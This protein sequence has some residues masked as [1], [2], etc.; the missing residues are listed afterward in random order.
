M[1]LHFP[2]KL[3]YRGNLK[4]IFFVILINFCERNRNENFSHIR[5]EK[6]EFLNLIIIVIGVNY[7]K[8]SKDNTI[9]LPNQC[10][11]MSKKSEKMYVEGNNKVKF[12]R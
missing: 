1:F 7:P 6:C 8:I 10:E 12:I 4:G 5:G 2:E 11:F 9:K 3:R